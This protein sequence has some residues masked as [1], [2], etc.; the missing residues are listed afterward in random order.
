MAVITV[1]WYVVD[2]S[3]GDRDYGLPLVVQFFTTVACRLL[4]ITGENG[5]N[6]VEKQCFAPENFLY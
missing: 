5:G 4:F 2:F 1:R 6:Y 3:C